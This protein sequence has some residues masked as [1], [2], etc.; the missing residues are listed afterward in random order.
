MSDPPNKPDV[1]DEYDPATCITAGDLR[2]LGFPI[3]EGVPDVAWVPRMA[4]FSAF[5][6]A[7][8]GPDGSM[9]LKFNVRF[10]HPFRWIQVD[11]TVDA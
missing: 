1:P 8:A 5:Q 4:F 10:T 11:F 2:Q 9:N 3:P 7:E 6:S